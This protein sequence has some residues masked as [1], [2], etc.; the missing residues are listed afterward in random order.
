MFSANLAYINVFYHLF[1]GG[2]P[3]ASALGN[4][5]SWL[6]VDPTLAADCWLPTLMLALV[7]ALKIVYDIARI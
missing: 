5:D 1:S 3:V 2:K 7:F 4:T 6:N